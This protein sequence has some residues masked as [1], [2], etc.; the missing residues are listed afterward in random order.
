M[1]DVTNPVRNSMLLFQGDHIF[2]L[3][4]GRD[5]NQLETES[6]NVGNGLTRSKAAAAA[7]MRNSANFGATICKPTGSRF[8][9]SPAGTEAAGC[10]VRLNGTVNGTASFQRSNASE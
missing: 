1:F 2:A 10:P 6:R 5:F 4:Y 3:T 8:E 9:S 7:K